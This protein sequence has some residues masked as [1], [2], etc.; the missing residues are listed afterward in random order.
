MVP[1]SGKA[2]LQK[3][4]TMFAGKTRTELTDGH[5]WFSVFAR[6]PES[7]FTRVQRLTSCLV[8]LLLSM[9]ASAMW[10]GTV[11]EGGGANAFKL[12][13][14]ALSAAQVSRKP[15]MGFRNHICGGAGV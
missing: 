4:K 3:F 13:P 5:L 6:P 11:P 2:E 8:L 15:E 9:L 10:Y 7:R 12:G 14:F 1:I